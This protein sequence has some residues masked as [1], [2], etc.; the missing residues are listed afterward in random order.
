[1]LGIP[2]ALKQCFDAIVAD[3]AQVR[4]Y[5]AK[6]QGEQVSGSDL[7]MDFA[8]KIG[9]QMMVAIRVMRA[10]EEG[11]VPLLPQVVSRLIRH[12]YGAE[13]HWR[14]QFEPGVTIVHGCGLVI[15]HAAKIGK[16]CILFHNVTLGESM[17][18]VSKIQGAPTLGCDVHIGPGA[19]L[20]GP[21]TIG[22]LSKVMAGSVV[23]ESVPSG[24]LVRPAETLI[25]SRNVAVLHESTDDGA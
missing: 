24:S 4:R 11:G 5:R 1:M 21:I 10:F 9:F 17:D 23:S 20:L 15:S 12:L 2:N 3:H 14:A 18:P 7:P 6:Y 19:T 13:I 16:G 22:D 8:K 25:T